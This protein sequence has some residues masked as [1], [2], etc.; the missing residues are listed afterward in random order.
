MPYTFLGMA[1]VNSKL[2]ALAN[3][4]E[5]KTQT[6]AAGEG[7]VLDLLREWRWWN[8]GRAALPMLGC[9]I[10]WWAVCSDVPMGGKGAV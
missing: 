3:E 1:S 2:F 7:A 5:T 4:K 6:V 9:G 8:A 10:G